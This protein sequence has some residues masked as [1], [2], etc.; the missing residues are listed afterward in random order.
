MCEP[1]NINKTKSYSN[2]LIYLGLCLN[3]KVPTLTGDS[4]Q[5]AVAIAT[6]TCANY[7]ASRNVH[8]MWNVEI[9]HDL[10]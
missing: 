8:D 10:R 9:Y 6:T 5:S 7:M 1:R 2:R 4:L 3:T